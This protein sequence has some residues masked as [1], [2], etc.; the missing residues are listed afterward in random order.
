M[1][2]FSSPA[3][4]CIARRGTEAYYILLQAGVAVGVCTRPAHLRSTRACAVRVHAVGAA[5]K[6]LAGAPPM[7]D[8]NHVCQRQNQASEEW[9]RMSVFRSTANE[10]PWRASSSQASVFCSAAQRAPGC[11][12]RPPDYLC[13]WTAVAQVVSGCLTALHV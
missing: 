3:C 2:L 5:K 1:A 4:N 12:G 13:K 7:S 8:A 10:T 9:A 11:A 6:M